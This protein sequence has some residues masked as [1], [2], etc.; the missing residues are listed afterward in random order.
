MPTPLEDA[1]GIPAIA[2]TAG[3]ATI[4]SGIQGVLRKEGFFQGVVQ[5]Y[6]ESA[7]E[8]LGLP[9]SNADPLDPNFQLQQQIRMSQLISFA[10]MVQ[11]KGIVGA[12]D[13]YATQIFS[14]QGVEA[15][16]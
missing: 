14:R 9:G 6:K 12:L 13:S 11:S 5:A 1:T 7:L 8:F 15:I 2:T 4:T 3:F 10:T 16:F